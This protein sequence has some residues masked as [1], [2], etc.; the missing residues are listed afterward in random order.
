MKP[1]VIAMVLLAVTSVTSQGTRREYSKSLQLETTSETSAN[2]SMGDLDGDGDLD[3]VLAK[4]RHWPLVNRV[5]LNDGRGGFVASDLAPGADRSYSTVLADLDGNGTL[6]LVVSNDRPDGKVVYFNDG[7]G[8]FTLGGGWGAPEWTTRNATVADLNGDG[9]P[10]I[11]AANRGGQSGYCLNNGA[12]VF[13]ATPCVM[14]EIESATSIVVADFN[15]DKAIDL[16]VPHRDGGQSRVF[17]NRGPEGFRADPFG[18]A[19]SNARAGAAGDLNGDGWADLVVGDERTGVRVYLN[20]KA[21]Q[22][23]AGVL[24]GDPA[25]PTGAVHIADMN[26][27]G[28]LDVLIGY[29]NPGP[30]PVVFFGDGSGAR[31]TRVEFGDGRGAVYGIDTGDIDGDGFPDIATARSQAPNILYFSA[32]AAGPGRWR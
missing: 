11:I 3:L 27:D 26:R 9:A 30:K 17:L 1:L 6:D 31:F 18:P 5:L 12:G 10:D 29:Y 14:L 23:R 22:L 15:N 7:K 16:A 8:R 25:L 24:L 19:V 28:H 21:G 4:G 13:D 20:D 2:V 32:P